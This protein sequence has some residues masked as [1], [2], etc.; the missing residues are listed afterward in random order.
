MFR[1]AATLA[2]VLCL[3][4]QAHAQ[5]FAS[6]F[7]R[8]PA[9]FGHLFEPTTGLI[10][11]ASGAAAA[12]VHPKDDAIATRLHATGDGWEEMFDG[13]S[14]IG[15]GAT[16]GAAALG[17]YVVGRAAHAPELA[18]LGADLVRG[19]IVGGILA[20]GI[21][22]AVPRARPTG[23]KYSFPSGHTEAAFVTATVLERHYGWKAGVPAY[24][25]AAYVGASRL[26]EY[27]HFTSDV[28][29]GAGIGMAA[30]RATTFERAHQTIS[31]VPQV[32]HTSVA[33]VVTIDRHD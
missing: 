25:L 9:D 18:S 21:K 31:I 33:A 3:A 4:P 22:L 29:F 2:L 26:A 10:V 12:A 23:S 19:Q 7:T 24:A 30:G 5:S 32:T 1:A 28:L 16:Q 17:I 6:L 8:L 15:N 27:Q 20:D 14:P 13:G 11:G